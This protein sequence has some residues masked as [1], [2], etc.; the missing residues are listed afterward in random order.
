MK[1]TPKERLLHDVLRDASA[2]LRQ[3]I[4]EASLKELRQ[5]RVK[6][7]VWQGLPIAIAAGFVLSAGLL[8]YSMSWPIKKSQNGAQLPGSV[9]TTPALPYSQIE[10]VSTR[11]PGMEVVE[12]PRYPIL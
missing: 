9:Q 12:S 4:F 2:G 6:R 11:G 1:N 8:F 3:E 10:V 7:K 5:R